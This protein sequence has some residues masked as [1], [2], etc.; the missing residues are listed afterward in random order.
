MVWDFLLEQWNFSELER[1]AGYGYIDI[2]YTN[3][4]TDKKKPGEGN[5]DKLDEVK[6]R[7]KV[8]FTRLKKVIS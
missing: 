4:N 6:F 2:L 3:V 5:T 8:F 1:G 7:T